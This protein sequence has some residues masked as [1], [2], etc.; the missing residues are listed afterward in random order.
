[1]VLHPLLEQTKGLILWKKTTQKY[2]TEKKK[3]TEK[4]QSSLIYE[5]MLGRAK[6]TLSTTF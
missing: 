4:D 2:T 6:P 3:K 1:M 5:L